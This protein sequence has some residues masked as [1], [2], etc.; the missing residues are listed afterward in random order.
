MIAWLIRS[1]KNQSNVDCVR[2]TT[3]GNVVTLP[4]SKET[5]ILIILINMFQE[6]VRSNFIFQTMYCLLYMLSSLINKSICIG[7]LLFSVQ[8]FATT[9]QEIDVW[10]YFFRIRFFNSSFWVCSL[11]ECLNLHLPT[12]LH[13]PGYT[14]DKWWSTSPPKLTVPRVARFCP[15]LSKNKSYYFIINSRVRRKIKRFVEQYTF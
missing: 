13:L 1:I 7:S 9:Q 5:R 4:C 15:C 3:S 10:A 8:Y 11:N 6:H 14:C 2:L 12:M